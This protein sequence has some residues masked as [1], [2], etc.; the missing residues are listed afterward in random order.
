MANKAYFDITVD[1]EYFQYHCK[2]VLHDLEIIPEVVSVELIK[3][4]SDILVGVH[5]E[6]R[7][8][9]I[10]H[11]IMVRNWCKHLKIMK[12][13]PFTDAELKG[14]NIN[15]LTSKNAVLA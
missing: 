2:A 13:V 3:D 11:K 10:A 1:K 14:L 6:M 8:I 12:V 5:A 9:F 4:T 15:S 7:V